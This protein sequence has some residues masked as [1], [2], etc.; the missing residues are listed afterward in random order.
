LGF[1]LFNGESTM[2]QVY[3]NI[4]ELV[5]LSSVHKKDGRNL[6]P[7]D[8]GII[9]DGAIVFDEKI[10]WVGTS[11]KL[12]PEYKDLPTKSLAGHVLIPEIVDCHTHIPFGGNRA[13]EYAMRLNGADYQQIAEAGGGI[14]HTVTKSNSCDEKEL[15]SICRKRIEKMASY[16]VGSFEIKSG[17]GLDYENEKR[18]T[19]LI[20]K[21]KKEFAP[22]YQIKNTYLAA[23]AVPKQFKN[24]STYLNEIVIPLLEELAPL[25]IIDA[26]DIFHEKGYFT[27]EDTTALFKK[28]QELKIDIKSH[29]DEFNDNGGALLASHH[30]A[31]STDHLMCTGIDGIQALSKSRT[32]A[33]LL[34]G[35]S[36]FLGKSQANARAFLDKGCKVAIASDFNPGSCHY[37]NVLQIAAMVAP[38]YQMNLCELWASITHNASHAMGLF[39]QGALKKG[40]NSR[41]SIFKVDELNQITYDWGVN[42][43]TQG[44]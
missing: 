6:L 3:K 20:D 10:L 22:K 43:F 1:P 34:P 14:L 38:T 16:G 19:L 25:E 24:S 26:V 27:R 35:T 42:H 9:K 2:A 41:F 5:T 7:E 15:L 31:L 17:Y 37:D 28:A 23:H 40:L 13:S 21:L 11:P 33:T 39:N 36:F 30:N 12:P 8:L 4:S 44:I 18:L 29:A 32:V